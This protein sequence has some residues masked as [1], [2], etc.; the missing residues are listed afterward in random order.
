MIARYRRRAN[1]LHVPYT[2]LLPFLTKIVN[3]ATE[4]FT[5]QNKSKKAGEIASVKGTRNLFARLLYLAITEK[6]H[7]LDKVLS[8]LLTPIPAECAHPDG[9]IPTTPKNAVVDLFEVNKSG[10]ESLADTVVIA[11]MFF[12][13]NLRQP[14]PHNLRGVVRHILIKGLKMT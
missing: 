2:S 13:R 11:G 3:F 10:P 9:S 1:K 12:L 7:Q 14:L 8:F 6:Y 5:K 4:N